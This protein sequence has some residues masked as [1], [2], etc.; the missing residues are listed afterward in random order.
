M[1]EPAFI[2][3]PRLP[4]PTRIIPAKWGSVEEYDIP[5]GEK[6]AV[7]DR[8]YPFEPVPG[9]DEEMFDLHAEKTFRVSDFRVVRDLGENLL[10][11]PYYPESGGT[12][13]DWIPE[14]PLPG[15]RLSRRIRGTEGFVQTVFL[16]SREDS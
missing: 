7:L 15:K 3:E 14:K 6:T 1:E 2:S 8:L 13:I 5:T 12:V 10:V 9:L 4:F 16:G 11:S